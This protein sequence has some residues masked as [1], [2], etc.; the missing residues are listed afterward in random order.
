MGNDKVYDVL[1]VGGGHAGLSAALTLYR[2]LHSVLILDTS[3]PRDAW[4]QPTHVVSGW[5]GRQAEALRATARIELANTGLVD[6]ELD[7][8]QSVRR[9]ADGFEIITEGGKHFGGRKLLIAVGKGNVFPDIPGFAENYPERI[10]HCMFTFGYEYRGAKQ[11]G[12]LADGALSSPLH[13]AMVVGDTKKFAEQITVFTNG[14]SALK[15]K[16]ALE[17]KHSSVNFDER[18][19]LQIRR[20]ASGLG[21]ELRMEGELLETVDFLVHQPSTRID[22]PLVKQLSLELDDRGDIKNIPPFFQT[23]VAGVFVAGDCA[24]PFKIIPMAMFMG[25]QAGAGIAR[26]LAAD[27][28]AEELAESHTTKD[29]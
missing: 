10:F 27:S 28:L 8:A 14:D 1:I 2:H 18:R 16:M 23:D 13:A 11:A 15:E 24:T 22:T 9:V 6:F 25:A 21:L 19:I 3:K 5:E 26:S 29:L 12:L 17:I 7:E 4:S 20:T